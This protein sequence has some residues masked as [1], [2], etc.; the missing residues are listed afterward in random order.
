MWNQSRPQR[1]CASIEGQAPWWRTSNWG[2]IS[3]GSHRRLLR[4]S[5]LPH[6]GVN[7]H[8]CQI[9]IP[10]LRGA[11]LLLLIS[12]LMLVNG[13]GC[14]WT[15][16]QQPIVLQSYVVSIS[17][18]DMPPSLDNHLLSTRVT[19]Y[20][21]FPDSPELALHDLVRNGLHWYD[22]WPDGDGRLTYQ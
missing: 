12:I 19:P 6:W 4:H 3:R 10:W 15:I 17:N 13:A 18:G 5:A 1:S 21:R 22:Y 14:F 7:F 11:Q 16:S 9:V 20:D 8:C 2:T